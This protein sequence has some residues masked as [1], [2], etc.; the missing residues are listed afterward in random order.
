MR[1]AFLRF[2]PSRSQGRRSPA[3]PIALLA[4]ATLVPV[5]A[6]SADVVVTFFGGYFMLKGDDARDIDDVLY[7]NAGFLTLEADDFN[8]GIFGGEVHFGVGRFLEVGA[9]AGFYQS[10]VGSVYRDYVNDNGT[11]IYQ[12]S[13]LRIV[14]YTFTARVFPA[15]RDAPVQPYVGGGLALL[16]WRYSEEGEFVDFNNRGE[17]FVDRFVDSG[18]QAAPVGLA[19]VRFRF[20]DNVLAGGEFRYQA[21]KADLDPALGFAGDTLDL[22]GYTWLFTVGIGF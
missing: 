10:T 20:S 18:Y 4:L 6:A 9:G 14:P 5:K 7:Q 8:N 19:G 11:E 21:A 1:E 12:E 13:K 16:Y 17:V 2:L 15:G 3:L 22:G